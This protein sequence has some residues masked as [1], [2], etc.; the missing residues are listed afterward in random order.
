VCQNTFSATTGTVF[1]RL[2]H[3]AHTVSRV[4]TLLAYGTVRDKKYLTR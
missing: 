3:S 2:R 4:V 1:Y